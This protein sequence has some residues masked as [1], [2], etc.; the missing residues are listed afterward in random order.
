MNFLVYVEDF[1]FMLLS[2]LKIP[3]FSL[4]ACSHIKGVRVSQVM[5]CGCIQQALQREA[6]LKRS[7]PWVFHQTFTVQMQPMPTKAKRPTCSLETNSGGTI[8][9]NTVNIIQMSYTG[10]Q[11]SGELHLIAKTW[12]KLKRKVC[13]SNGQ[14][15]QTTV[16]CIY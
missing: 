1:Q 15:I 11:G 12:V 9:V 2:Y 10:I 16:L 7:P 6:I 13:V 3:S 4:Y 14:K 8:S 5:K